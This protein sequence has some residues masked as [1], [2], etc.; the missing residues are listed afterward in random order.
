MVT[1]YGCTKL[2]L[3][4]RQSQRIHL[5][6]LLIKTGSYFDFTNTSFM[7]SSNTAFN[8]DLSDSNISSVTIISGMFN[9][10][11]ALSDSN[12]GLIHGTFSK[13]PNW[14]YGLVGLSYP[15]R[16]RRTFRR[17]PENAL[18]ATGTFTMGS[19]VTEAGRATDETEHNVTLTEGF[20]LGKYE[21][22]QAQYETVMT[23]TQTA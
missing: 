13:N 9:N 8:Q 7:F 10:T 6:S 19:P 4:V 1:T 23:G 17:Q 3:Y 11:P 15:T 18:G 5:I 21:V 20:Y 2:W 16:S 14:P 12:K 22:T